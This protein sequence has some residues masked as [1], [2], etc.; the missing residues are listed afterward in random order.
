MARRGRG[1]NVSTDR[2]REILRRHADG[3]RIGEMADA[4]GLSPS[5]VSRIVHR[6]THRGVVI[7]TRLEPLAKSHPRRPPAPTNPAPGLD[8]AVRK[9]QKEAKATEG[10]STSVHHHYAPKPP[11]DGR[12]T[13]E[14]GQTFVSNGHNYSTTI[15]AFG[16]MIHMGVRPCNGCADAASP[17]ETAS[18]GHSLII[19]R[20]PI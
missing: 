7:E 14:C 17:R 16:E 1:K 19:R 3:W 6:V 2:A 11:I 15:T 5:T 9:V 13:T 20:Q 8:A 12:V 10:G 4:Y 18:W